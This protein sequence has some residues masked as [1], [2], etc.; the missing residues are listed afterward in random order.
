[1]FPRPDFR[2]F[3]VFWGVSWRSSFVFRTFCFVLV[4]VLCVSVVVM[5]G[6]LQTQW[7]VVWR[8]AGF[9]APVIDVTNDILHTHAPV[10]NAGSAMLCQAGILFGCHCLQHGG[11]SHTPP[12]YTG[13]ARGARRCGTQSAHAVSACRDAT[14]I[15][16]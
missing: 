3:F 13:H 9:A 2:W 16:G 7:E 8:G 4:S 5:S 10:P 6:P 15:N 14:W 1:M 11:A 12:R